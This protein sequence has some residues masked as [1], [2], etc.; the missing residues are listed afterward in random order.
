M[1]CFILLIGLFQLSFPNTLIA[2]NLCNK[3]EKVIFSCE[4]KNKNASVCQLR[5]K[6]LIYKFGS[7]EKIELT[8]KSKPYFSTAMYPGGGGA[9][10]RFRNKE[11]S[12]IVYSFIRGIREKTE[13]AGIYV[14]KKDKLL[15]DIECTGFKDEIY[16][17][18]TFEGGYL[19]EEFKEKGFD[20]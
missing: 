13:G 5:N 14:L 18:R 17:I 2:N 9:H 7:N 12:Y 8:L 20:F 6:Q 10:L 3:D 11:Y 15:A 1:K 4:I 16:G 19:E